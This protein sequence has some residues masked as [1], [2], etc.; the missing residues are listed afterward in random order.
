MTMKSRILKRLGQ[1]TISLI[2]TSLVLPLPHAQSE[3]FY[4]GKT[5]KIIQGRRPGGTGD[6]RA[7]A[8]MKY[9]ADHI[10]GNPT[11]VSQYM[12]GGG[13]RL[14][15]NHV[16]QTVK[17][18]G[19]TLVN[20]GGGFIAN[21]ILGA[22][23]VKYDI[24]KMTYL[25]TGNSQGSWAFYSLKELGYD[26]IEKMRAKENIRIGTQNVGHDVYIQARLFAWVLGLKKARFVVGYSGP[27]LDVGLL[28]G[29]FD[30]RSSSIG[31][32][33]TRNR[34]WLKKKVITPHTVMEVPK[35]FRTYHPDFAD[36]P[37]LGS[38]VDTKE[39]R[40]VMKLRRI[41]RQVGSPYVLPPGV[42]ADRV[43]ILKRAFE[44]TYKDP[45]L[46]KTWKKWTG[47]DPSPILPDD[48]A[49]AVAALPK[50]SKIIQIF[51]QLAGGGPMPWR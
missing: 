8:I 1:F 46:P 17:P 37:S 10:P 45:R 2:L 16:Y 25:G 32:I 12:P 33:I 35:G 14:A 4:K 36:L 22:R 44:M 18:D 30:A 5:I 34:E 24:H 11:L 51:R 50:D 43:K 20:I 27:E 21:A 48:Q 41:V 39:E 49:K 19:L 31:T 38:F 26:S 42:P 47:D 15:A 7:R 29:E 23:G 3:P 40:E 13:G 28:R 9:L 6:L